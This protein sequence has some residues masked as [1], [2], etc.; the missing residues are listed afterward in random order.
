M[1][2]TISHRDAGL[3]WRGLPRTTVLEI[4]RAACEQDPARP[5]LIFD[6]GL[7]VT[8]GELLDRAE[9]FAAY[10]H[11]YLSPGDRVAIMLSNRAEFMIAWLALVANRATLV[12]MNT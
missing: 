8:R 1:S 3:R 2:T 12:S 11:D 6:D 7:I 4:A 5:A 9:R 10:L